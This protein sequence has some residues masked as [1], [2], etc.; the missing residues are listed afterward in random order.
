MSDYVPSDAGIYT[1]GAPP[2][3]SAASCMLGDF[4]HELDDVTRGI[5]LDTFA[6]VSLSGFW[7]ELPWEGGSQ[8]GY[9]DWHVPL[10][11]QMCKGTSS[12]STDLPS[13]QCLERFNATTEARDV[14]TEY[15]DYL[16]VTTAFARCTSTSDVANCV[17]DFFEGEDTMSI[18]KVNRIKYTIKVTAFTSGMACE[19]KVFIYKHSEDGAAVEFQRRSGDCVAFDDIYRRASQYV[20]THANN[21]FVDEAS[22][23]KEMGLP[24]RVAFAAPAQQSEQAL[25]PLLQMASCS[26]APELQAQAAAGLI[27]IAQ[28]PQ[29]MSEF[30]T[31]AVLVA[32]QKLL[33]VQRLAVIY[34]TACLVALLAQSQEFAH[35]SS[36][37]GLPQ[38]MQERLVS[39]DTDRVAKEQLALA[40]RRIECCGSVH[41]EHT[42]SPFFESA[43]ACC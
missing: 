18:T 34:P 38:L 3:E 14:P 19:L 12:P 29:I 10:G 1:F 27:S 23:N 32:L 2:E 37:F 13:S 8:G 35:R 21:R 33:L 22:A 24:A 17:L 43:A 28:D 6:P 41:F 40:V 36:D 26:E 42:A 16:A 5:T 20:M 11:K 7:E 39:C 4:Y 30:C 31:P 15:G 25:V 9:A